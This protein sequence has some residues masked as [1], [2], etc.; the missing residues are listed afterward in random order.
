MKKTIYICDN[1]KMETTNPDRVIG[2][3]SWQ[4]KKSH[5]Q[6]RFENINFPSLGCG[7]RFIEIPDNLEFCSLNCFSEY[8]SSKIK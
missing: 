7:S 3:V 2:W 8:I 6:V 1:C 4:Q 5:L